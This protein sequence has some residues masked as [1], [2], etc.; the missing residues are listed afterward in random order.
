MTND[1]FTSRRFRAY[2]RKLL[3]EH[4]RTIC[5]AT[6][7][8][9]GIMLVAEIWTALSS[10]S[11]YFSLENPE[12]NYD[13]AR[14][15]LFFTGALIFLVGGCISSS[16][17]FTDGQRKAGRIHVLTTPVSPFESWLA[18]W[19]L[20]VVGYIVVFFACFY[21]ADLVRVAIFAPLLP[22][23][24]VSFVSVIP[25]SISDRE[26]YPTMW[27]FYFFF[28]SWFVLGSFFFPKRPLLATS[29][30]IFIIGMLFF[31]V[32]LGV[33]DP[34]INLS[35]RQSALL[36]TIANLWLI[37]HGLLNWWLSYQRYKEMEII[38]HH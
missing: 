31:F 16:R 14:E 29:I 12:S 15:T 25:K 35:D 24:S 38:D 30:C 33:M 36:K 3:T 1:F 34:F 20:Y 9:L 8:L 27:F 6:A 19:L 17:L 21:L 28:T 22:K 7:I 18:R 2:F 23:V 37:L 11:Y 32:L 26:T 13:P 10:Y 4:W 5:V